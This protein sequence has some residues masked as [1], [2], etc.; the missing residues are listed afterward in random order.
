MG[1]K[2]LEPV[3]ERLKAIPSLAHTPGDMQGVCVVVVLQA[4]LNVYE[5]FA[6]QHCN[7]LVDPPAVCHEVEEAVLDLKH[8]LQ[9]ASKSTVRRQLCILAPLHGWTLRWGVDSCDPF[10]VA[11]AIPCGPACVA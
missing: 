9:L 8:Q 6:M 10:R 4:E 3:P 2:G 11:N 7:G 1:C 5:Q